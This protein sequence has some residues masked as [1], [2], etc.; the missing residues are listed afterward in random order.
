MV[1]T[2]YCTP[3][4][5][6]LR[7]MTIEDIGVFTRKWRKRGTNI[8]NSK[9]QEV[10]KVV[11]LD[12]YI[13]KDLISN[14]GLDIMTLIDDAIEMVIYPSKETSQCE[15]VNAKFN[16]GYIVRK[17]TRATSRIRKPLPEMYLS[18][19]ITEFTKGLTSEF[20][21]SV[22]YLDLCYSNILY[23]L[24]RQGLTL[25]DIE[26]DIG[27]SNIKLNRT[28]PFIKE[29]VQ[30]YGVGFYPEYLENTKKNNPILF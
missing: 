26:N 25:K 21:D 13:D 9:K 6:E 18:L 7:L 22:G 2:F 23:K 29:L 28:T 24:F 27:L 3:T 4:I 17:M 1:L 16:N 10:Q 30:T 19:M 11:A 12:N 5:E 20:D 15:V 8:I 14:Y